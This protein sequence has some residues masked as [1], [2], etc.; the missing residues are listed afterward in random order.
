MS[1]AHILVVDDEPDIRDLVKEILEDENYEVSTAENG[2]AAREARRARRPDLI[3]LDIWMPD[4]D[5]ISLLKEWAEGDGLPCPVIMMS[6]H[7][8]VETAVEATRLGAWDFIEKPLSMAKLLLTLERALEADKL[9]R[10][11]AGLKRHARPVTEPVGR[12]ETVQKL[13]A[14]AQ[15]IAQHE[16]PVLISGEPGTGKEI[17]ARYVHAHSPRRGGPFVDVG[18]G[19]IARENSALELFGSEEGER[20]HYGRLEQASGGTLFL[21]ELA[22][23]APETQA[24]LAGALENGSFLRLGGREPVHLNVRVIAATHRDL[25]SEVAAGRFREDLY[26]HLNVLPIR[27]PPLREHCEDVPD[28]LSFYVNHF[29]DQE[30]LPYRNF[31]M[32]ARNRL[33]NY[34]WPGNIRELKNLVQRLLILGGAEEITLEEVESAI[35]HTTPGRQRDISQIPLDLPLREA[36]EQFERAYLLQQFKECDGNVARLA[37]KVGME[38][39]N[40]YRKLRALGIDPKRTPEDE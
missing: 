20:L 36:R 3:L 27:L 30:S 29:V 24:K 39:T 10:E 34:G 19:S 31:T 33:R 21:D 35:S 23:M 7:G 26:Y 25:E 18:V 22:D 15:R 38:R 28:L 1:S 13:K 17:Y 32:A 14:Q 16:A 2:A 40:L 6:G 11:N 4:I 8:T 37:E 12:S 9:R 5:G